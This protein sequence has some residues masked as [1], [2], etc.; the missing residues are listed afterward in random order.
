MEDFSHTLNSMLVEV[1][2]SI[3]SAEEKFLQRNNRINLSIR[4]M[5]LIECVGM[6][7]GSGKT[8]SE[9]ADYLKIARP[10]ATVA[11]NK[12]E[13]KGYL[14]RQGSERDRRIVHVVLTREGRKIE[15]YHRR[16][17]MNMVEELKQEFV[18]DEQECLLRTINKLNE[19]FNKD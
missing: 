2:H 16:Y 10:S 12:L 5:H 18:D 1:Y 13:K 11:V 15:T 9:I 14:Y 4:E 8:I 6:D 17:H 7:K 3:M 19:F